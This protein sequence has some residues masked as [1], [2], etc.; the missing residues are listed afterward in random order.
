MLS[1]C[2]RVSSLAYRATKVSEC[3]FMV[4]ME[5][6]GQRGMGEGLHTSTDGGRV[7]Q[8]GRM[9]SDPARSLV[10][11]LALALLLAPTLGC[12]YTTTLTV[13][14]F[15]IDLLRALRYN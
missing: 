3:H 9:T 5:G 10:L 1:V 11:S 15:R 4:V 12:V 8:Y 14:F 6:R 7:S 2:T 13:E